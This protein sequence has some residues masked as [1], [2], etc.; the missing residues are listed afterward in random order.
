[1]KKRD[2]VSLILAISMLLPLVLSST[3]WSNEW[4]L[5]LDAYQGVFEGEKLYYHFVGDNRIEVGLPATDG[6][7]VTVL[8]TP[9]AELRW[10]PEYID[11]DGGYN[12]YVFFI[13]EWGTWLMIK[14]LSGTE[15][16]STGISF[17]GD[18]YD[19]S[20]AHEYTYSAVGWNALEWWCANWKE[21]GVKPTS[22][23]DEW[24]ECP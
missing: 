23:W 1:M 14:D 7:D 10:G 12:Q 4:G 15:M 20:R 21:F 6:T 2:V 24:L 19:A 8:G 16:V 17:G 3:A 18:A 13:S 11:S 5:K 9:K 22:P